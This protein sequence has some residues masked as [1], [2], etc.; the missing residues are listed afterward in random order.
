MPIMN[1]IGIAAVLASVAF[2]AQAAPASA[3]ES[4]FHGSYPFA[5][6]ITAKSQVAL[7]S[8]ENVSLKAYDATVTLANSIYAPIEQTFIASIGEWKSMEASAQD[9]DFRNL[10][11]DSGFELMRINVGLDLLPEFGLSFERK[12]NVTEDVENLSDKM[13]D[14]IAKQPILTSLDERWV[15]Y[16]L[17]RVSQGDRF[18]KVESV[19]IKILPLP[20]LELAYDIHGNLQ[21]E[22]D[23]IDTSYEKLAEIET[24]LH[25]LEQQPGAVAEV[26]KNARSTAI[27]S[28]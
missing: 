19:D 10:I 26:S 23:K 12:G 16:V 17:R 1:K 3:A 18:R 15:F 14:H 6:V 7:E 21:E 24:R 28:E 22:K 20:G 11:R 2:Q 8:L 4:G 27:V 5:D 13:D 9:D 25:L